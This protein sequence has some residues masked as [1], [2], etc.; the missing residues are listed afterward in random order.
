M[1]R[2]ALPHPKDRRNMPELP[3]V[4]NTRRNLVR[5]GLPGCTITAANI[6]WANTVKKPSATELVEDLKD[7]TVQDV[8]RR[9]KYLIL[10]LSGGIPATFIVHLGMTGRLYVQ[11]Q[12][13]KPHPMTRHTFPLDDGRELRFE[14]GRKFGKLWLVD[15][16][17]E[18]LPAMSPE[19]FDDEFTVE[20]LAESFAGKKAPVKAL[21]LDQGIACGLG[22]LYADESLFLAGIHP[23]RPASALSINEV[24]YLRQ[25][26][27]EALTAAYGVYDRARD[28][29][30]PN[31]PTALT[32][33]SHPRDIKAA[34]P[35]CGTNMTAIRVR[36]RGT[37]FC[38][39]CQ[40]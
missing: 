13:Q 40:F 34:C 20:T 4:E 10:P 27:I 6:T 5:A 12:S 21:L 24:A 39:K 37:Y 28:R 25:S 31:P 2:D 11:P 38:S 22:N 16:P 3:E 14:D 32:T 1:N 8:Q 15:S 9:G 30:W 7:R 29:H 35:N 17:D 18:V 36:A 19:P 33:W 23:E 26:I